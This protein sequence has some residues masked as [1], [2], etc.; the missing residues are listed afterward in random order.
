MRA[1]EDRDKG[2]S[3][4]V[5][6]HGAKSRRARSRGR[7]RKTITQC[8]KGEGREVLGSDAQ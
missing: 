3:Q 4:K 5:S 8:T 1:E 2:A 6:G 7:R